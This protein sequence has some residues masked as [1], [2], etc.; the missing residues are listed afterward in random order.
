MASKIFL[1]QLVHRSQIVVPHE[2]SRLFCLMNFRKHSESMG[3]VTLPDDIADPNTN[4][5]PLAD[6]RRKA[7]LIQDYL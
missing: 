3:F 1:L 5:S 7:F 2:N 4:W 6:L